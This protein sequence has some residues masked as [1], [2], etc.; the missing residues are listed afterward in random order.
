MSLSPRKGRREYVL[1]ER[2]ATEPNTALSQIQQ[3]FSRVACRDQTPPFH[4]SEA[5]PI[6][7]FVFDQSL[8]DEFDD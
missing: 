5:E 6:P 8:P 7:E 4:P 1:G 3:L 2:V